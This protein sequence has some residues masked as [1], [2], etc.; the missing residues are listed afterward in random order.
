MAH[1]KVKDINTSTPRTWKPNAPPYG[2]KAHWESMSN[3]KDAAHCIEDTLSMP[4][5]LDEA[6]GLGGNP[7]HR[8]PPP[9][10]GFIG[11]AGWVTKEI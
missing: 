1:G 8:R 6:A 10:D 5:I 7:C 11:V 3:L 4:N 9:T 2:L